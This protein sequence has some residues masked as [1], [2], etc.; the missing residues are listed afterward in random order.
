[1]SWVRQPDL[2]LATSALVAIPSVSRNEATMAALVEDALRGCEWLKVERVG[3]NVVARTNLGHA[4]RVV[5]AGHLDTVPPDRNEQPVVDGDTLWGLGASDMKGGLAVMLDLAVTTPE[6]SVDVTWCFYAREE[7]ARSDS[8]LLELWRSRPDLLEADAAILGE[9]TEGLVE[10]GCQGTMR[11]EIGL[12]G[13]RAHT[14][15]PFMGRN[16]IHRLGA[17]LARVAGWE[18]RRVV[19]DGCT[20]VEQLQAV[21][22]QGG[23]APNVVPDA[24]G[25][26]L[27]FRY[28]PDRHAADAESFVRALLAGT[29]DETQGDS[30]EVVDG[31]E[32]A[33]PSLTHPLLAG[34][35]ASTGAPARAKVGWTDVASFWEHGVPAANFGP[36][37]PQLAHHP[38][39]RVTRAQLER[40]RAALAALIG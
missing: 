8:G 20:Y 21:A 3:D 33:P 1:M 11:L 30:V 17:V 26:T 34:L 9:P 27:N 32:G 37:D 35:V 12:V 2:L 23:V 13:V 29:V 22:V 40:T 5:L 18:G 6:P 10:A 4:Q 36:G 39:E 31:A 15:R 25:T 24:A 19:L 16:A 14:A 28:A 38:Q 7:I